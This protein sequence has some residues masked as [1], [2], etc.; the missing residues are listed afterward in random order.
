[1]NIEEMLPPSTDYAKNYNT[2]ID[3]GQRY[4][5]EQKIVFLGLARNIESK[6]TTNIDRLI[7]L[8][9]KAKKYK[10]VVFENDS[11]DNTRNIL[12]TL[13][14]TNSNITVLGEN[15]GRPQFGP[16]QDLERTAALAEYRN[17]L[18]RYVASNLSDYDFVVVTDLD[19]VDFST[20]GC[21]NS[22]GWFAENFETIDAI[23]GNAFEYKY[24]TSE[25]NKSL[26]NY[27]SWAF[28]YTWWN[29]LPQYDYCSYLPMV[30]FGFFIMPVGSPVIYV[31]S[32]FGGMTIYKL[33]K[34]VIELYDGYDCE[35]VCLH[36]NLKRSLNS[37]HLVLNPSQIM[38]V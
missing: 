35:H 31:N 7:Q 4:L 3:L 33:S 20:N 8:G 25:T 14:S 2:Y 9:Q 11:S 29:Q 26:W 22:F 30:W 37:F 12:N 16:V 27:D 28:R 13:A 1:M 6:I 17:I 36:Y 15:N 19:F 23:A 21:Y 32:A 5:S 10:I 18:L 38:L 24:V 34:Y